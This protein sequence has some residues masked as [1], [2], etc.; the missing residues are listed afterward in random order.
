M[1]WEKKFKKKDV[2][3]LKVKMAAIP[4]FSNHI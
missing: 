1:L 4:P 2:A 3:F